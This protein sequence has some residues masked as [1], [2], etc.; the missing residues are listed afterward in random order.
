[1]SAKVTIGWRGVIV[2][3]LFLIAFSLLIALGKSGDLLIRGV[4]WALILMSSALLLAPRFRKPGDT[5]QPD[6]N[7]LLKRWHRWA[8][9]ESDESE[10]R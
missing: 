5:P 10:R 9:D 6:R 2:F 8:M 7:T 1:M 4:I 3:G